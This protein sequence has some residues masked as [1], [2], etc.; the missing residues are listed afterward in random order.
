VRFDLAMRGRM[1]MTRGLPYGWHDTPN[2]HL[3]TLA[4]F[5]DWC[6]ES[7]VNVTE[8]Y[9]LTDGRVHPLSAEDNLTAEEALLFLE[10]SGRSKHKEP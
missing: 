3:F 1:P 8:A 10:A 7:Q 9:G 4:D 5:F 2:I 6:D